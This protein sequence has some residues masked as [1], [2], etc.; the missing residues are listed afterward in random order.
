M[1]FSQSTDYALRLLLYLHKFD[2]SFSTKQLA[3]TL[4][5]PYHLLSKL[6]QRLSVAGFVLTKR[7]KQGGVSLACEL[8]SIHSQGLLEAV[9]GPLALVKCLD[10]SQKKA[11]VLQDSC[12]MKLGLELVQNRLLTFMEGITVN[13]LIAT[14]KE[15][16]N[17]LK[18][19]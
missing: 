18:R 6:V 12:D 2:Q 11:C 8:E 9:E 3:S 17:E 5:I 13:Q 16:V 19:I 4:A 7:G 10:S 15:P 14:K 1:K